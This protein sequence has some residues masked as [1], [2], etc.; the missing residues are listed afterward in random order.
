[1]LGQSGLHSE[2][3]SQAN[4]IN[5]AREKAQLIKRKLQD[6]EHLSS[7]ASNRVKKLG[8]QCTPAIVVLGRQKQEE[9]WGSLAVIVQN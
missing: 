1:M 4:K 3:L 8:W 6:R 9:P 7:D 5:R 2:V